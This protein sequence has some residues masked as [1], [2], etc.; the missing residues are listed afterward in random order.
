MLSLSSVALFLTACHDYWFMAL[1]FQTSDRFS[2]VF[3]C[4]TRKCIVYIFAQIHPSA[5]TLM[6]AV[7]VD[8]SFDVFTKCF[9][10]FF[11]EV[12]GFLKNTVATKAFDFRSSR[13]LDCVKISEII[14][15]RKSFLQS[16]FS[17]HYTDKM[18]QQKWWA[19]YILLLLLLL[20][21]YQSVP[22]DS[23]I[24]EWGEQIC[25]W[26]PSPPPL[27]PIETGT[28]FVEVEKI[29]LKAEKQ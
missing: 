20:S 22:C 21:F 24:F 26:K 8:M 15:E 13:H 11:I 23:F 12:R 25:I 5:S 18:F 6:K 3:S 19:D 17:C 27:R 7:T 9:F 10:S 1:C 14:L 2:V 4:D 28:P 29:D 16:K